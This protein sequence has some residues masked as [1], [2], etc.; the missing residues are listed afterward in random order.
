MKNNLTGTNEDNK[1]SSIHYHLDLVVVGWLWLCVVVVCGFV[2]VLLVL[3][4]RGV[5]KF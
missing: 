5:V 1:K 2:W 4:W 3:V